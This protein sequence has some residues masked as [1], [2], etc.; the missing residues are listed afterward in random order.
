MMTIPDIQKRKEQGKK[1]TMLTSY[2]LPFAEIVDEAGIDMI[3]VG[4]SLGVVVQGMENTLSVTMDEMIY[5]TSIV[6]R[7]VKNAVVI[8]DMPFMSYQTGIEDAIRNAGR[9][10]QE[11]R[12]AGVKLEGRT[13]VLDRI[14]AFTRWDIPVMGHIGLTPQSIHKMGGFRVQG[15]DEGEAERLLSDAKRIEEAGAFSIILEGIPMRLAKDITQELSIPTIGIGAGPYCDGQVLVIYDMLG[16]FDR[17]VPKFVRRYADI[18]GESLKA[19]KRFKEDVEEG[20]FP[21]EEES[22]H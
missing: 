21:A 16:L 8:G 2:D 4:D 13:A 12:A 6:S 1:I 5:H 10:L 18:K 7:G 14:E 15:K 17:F 22:Y 9:F 11:G 3:L 19:I 20:R